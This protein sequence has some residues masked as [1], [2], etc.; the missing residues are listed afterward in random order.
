MISTRQDGFNLAT[1]KSSTWDAIIIG[2]GPSGLSASYQLKQCNLSYVVLEASNGVLSSYRYL[3]ANF[4]IA[5][6]INEITVD[7]LNLS[8]KFSSDHQLKRDELIEV[9]ESFASKHQ[10]NI[11][12]STKV[13]SI[14]KTRDDVF[15]I[16][17][18]Q[19]C[20]TANNVIMALAMNPT[21]RLPEF[22]TESVLSKNKGRMMH[23]AWYQGADALSVRKNADILIVGSG[24]YAL[25]VAKELWENKY[26]VSIA[27]GYDD[28]QIA[29]KNRHLPSIPI[30]LVDL[31]KND[32]QNFGRLKGLDANGNLSFEYKF[33]KVTDYDKIIFSTGYSYTPKMICHLLNNCMKNVEEKVLTHVNGV[34]PSEPGVYLV[35]MPVKGQN[36]TTFAEGDRFAKNVAQHCMSRKIASN[37][38][39]NSLF[40][41]N[42]DDDFQRV[43]LVQH[44]EQQSLIGSKK[45]NF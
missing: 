35:G 15:E 25:T 14:N 2:A 43:K 23:S 44:E 33:N 21:P 39:K 11:K 24:L 4:K 30:K 41:S 31:T 9:Y 40:S 34:I 17:T 36:T 29:D 22:I 42:Q 45:C 19:G 38:L 7:G 27:C 32:I 20:Y 8:Q 28:K 12:F 5:Q 6:P 13:V 1:N 18:D 10:I 37:L 16:L 26:N 3:W